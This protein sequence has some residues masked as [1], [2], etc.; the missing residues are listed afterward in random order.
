MIPLRGLDVLRS[1][2][3]TLVLLTGVLPVTAPGAVPALAA[4]APQP[5]PAA[6]DLTPRPVAAV[7][8]VPRGAR[9]LGRVPAS[10]RLDFDIVLRPRD[11]HGL[12]ALATAVSVPGSPEYRRFLRPAQFAARFGQPPAIVGRVAAALRDVG[13]PP[14]PISA[15][16]LVIPVATTVGRARVILRTG[17]E[18]Y[19][20]AS[21]R[22]A[23]ANTSA[24]RLPATVARLTQAVLGLNDLATVAPANAPRPRDRQQAAPAGPARPAV[25]GP[26]PCQAAVLAARR[27]RG[28]TYDQLARAY[29]V[30]SRAAQGS[31]GA[32]LTVALFEQEPWWARDIAE[33]QAC[34]GTSAPVSKVLVDGGAGH[35]PGPNAEAVLDI[36]TVIALAPRASVLV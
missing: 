12:H 9:A 32:G 8:A 18:R 16:H 28:W 1:A 5:V 24:P 15:N 20:L 17:F 4:P 22:V 13:L 31:E 19:R 6:A 26:Q 21:G 36:E 3:I 7:P 14:G 33:F 29:S 35:G 23:L 11:P 27:N 10:R 30:T 34:Y 2:A 25:T